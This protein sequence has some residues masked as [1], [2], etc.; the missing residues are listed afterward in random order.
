MHDQLAVRWLLA[1]EI[2]MLYGIEIPSNIHKTL[3]P[4]RT[5]AA[6]VD[7]PL[8]TCVQERMWRGGGLLDHEVSPRNGHVCLLIHSGG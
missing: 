4:V 3:R 1:F 5:S 2:A 8:T 7:Q 6:G